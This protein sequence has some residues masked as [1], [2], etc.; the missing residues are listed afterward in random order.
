M[1]HWLGVDSADHVRRG[2]GLGIAQIGHGQK[3]GLTRMR[4][5]DGLVYYSPR[6]TLDGSS[7]LRAFTAVGRIEDDELWQADEGDFHPWRRRVAYESG[8]APVPLRLV[9]SDLELTRPP[10]WGYQ[11]R[12]GLLGLSPADF[13][14][15]ER[16]FRTGA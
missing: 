9:Q 3:A 8:G 4:A 10:N 14:R 2:V 5:G 15:I 12:R 6:E 16:A 11:L 13:V 1:T 7:P